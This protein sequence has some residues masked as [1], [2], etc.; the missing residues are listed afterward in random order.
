MNKPGPDT[1]QAPNGSLIGAYA[2]AWKDPK[3]FA[4]IG[5]T[6]TGLGF[7]QAMVSGELPQLPLGDTLAFH[8]SAVESGAVTFRCSVDARHYNNIGSVHGAVPAALIDSASGC[9][10]FSTLEK[11]D[12]WTTLSLSVDFLRAPNTEGELRCEGRVVRAGR[13]TAVA[14]AE[15]YD[16]DGRLCARGSSQCLITRG[17]WPAS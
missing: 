2:A 13:R 12:A 10:V 8:L 3:A 5:R 1:N 9:A 15:L 17:M 6:M 4:E 11:G 16:A 14:D 7:L